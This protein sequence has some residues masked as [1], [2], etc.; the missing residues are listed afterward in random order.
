MKHL[1]LLALFVC[2]SATTFSCAQSKTTQKERSEAIYKGLKT[3]IESNNYKFVGEWVFNNKRRSQ[4]ESGSN[5]LIV[6]ASNVDLQVVA[7]DEEDKPI[8]IKGE[9]SN[10]WSF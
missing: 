10:F 2:F 5:F 1:M 3:A 8:T 4:L 7:I 9:A 6:S